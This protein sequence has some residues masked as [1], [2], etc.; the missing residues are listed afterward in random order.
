MEGQQDSGKG[1]KGERW[2][3]MKCPCAGLGCGDGWQSGNVKGVISECSGQGK[4]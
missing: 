4:G 3:G 2:S 1:W